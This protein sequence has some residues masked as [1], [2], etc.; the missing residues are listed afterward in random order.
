MSANMVKWS[1]LFSNLS[2]YWKQKTKRCIDIMNETNSSEEDTDLNADSTLFL[3]APRL[4][5]LSLKNVFSQEPLLQQE[6]QLP[7]STS[8][9]RT[10]QQQQDQK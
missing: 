7:T 3:L 10:Q 9:I 8:P 6:C 1:L 5:S 2:T 4:T